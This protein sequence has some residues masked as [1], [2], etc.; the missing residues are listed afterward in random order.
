MILKKW[1]DFS[2]S[3]TDVIAWIHQMTFKRPQNYVMQS[4]DLVGAI[5]VFSWTLFIPS[6]DFSPLHLISAWWQSLSRFF[7]GIDKRVITRQLSQS[8]RVLFFRIFRMAPS[9]LSSETFFPTHKAVKRGLKCPYPSHW[10]Y[11][12]QFCIEVIL[13]R[14]LSFLERPYNF[15]CFFFDGGSV[16]MS[17]SASA[18][19]VSGSIARAG[20][21]STSLTYSAHQASCSAS[22]LSSRLICPWWGHHWF[23][24]SC[25]KPS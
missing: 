17:S 10:I 14:G 6:W 11:P 24:S 8:L 25:R 21:F 1:F 20:L 16:L 3:P 23:Q 2:Y 22:I 18:S 13:A 9:D 19:V 7:L 15:I 12:E 5:P 4:E